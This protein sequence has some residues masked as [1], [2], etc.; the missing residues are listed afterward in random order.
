[1]SGE[2]AEAEG[3]AD[4]SLWREPGHVGLDPRIPGSRPEPQAGA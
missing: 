1:M 2:G 4:S 3:G